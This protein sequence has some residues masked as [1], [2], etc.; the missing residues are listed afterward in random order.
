VLTANDVRLAYGVAVA[1]DVIQL[2]L[3]PIGWSFGDEVIDVA[4]MIAISRLLGFHPLL[5]PTFVLEIIPVADLLP[6]W[7]AC[8]A[9]L[10]SLRRRQQVSSPPP[11]SSGPIIDAESRRVDDGPAS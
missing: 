8:V 5:L 11:P 1:V 7:T 10:V 9:L 6:S 2:L 3:G 4:A